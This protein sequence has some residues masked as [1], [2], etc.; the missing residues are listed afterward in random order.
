MF[1]VFV[2]C[3]LGR[4][5]GILVGKASTAPPKALIKVLISLPKCMSGAAQE[6]SVTVFTLTPPFLIYDFSL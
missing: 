3:L 1:L 5:E 4:N 6:F 2:L